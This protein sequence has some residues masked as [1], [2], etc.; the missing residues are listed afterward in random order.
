VL[1]LNKSDGGSRRFILVEMDEGVCQ[2]VAAQ[3][4]KRAVEGYERVNGD[5]TQKVEPLGGGFRFCRLGK[6]LFDETGNI[7]ES[8]SF[9]DLA[10]HVFFTETGVPIPQR[11]TG[12]TPLLGVHEGK[13]VYLLFNGVLGD[14]R[15]AG[16]NVL[17]SKVLASLPAHPG[18]KVIYGEGCLLSPQRLKREGIVFKQVPYEIK[19]S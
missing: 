11:A 18:S 8:V 5:K 17:T 13:A 10:A 2:N 1:D 16:G 14:R 4:L 9:A 19:V 3:R 7:A 15:P 12:Q 6:S